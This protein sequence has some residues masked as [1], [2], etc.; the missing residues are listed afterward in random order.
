MKQNNLNT[1]IALRKIP[2]SLN[3]NTPEIITDKG[4]EKIKIIELSC[5]IDKWEQ[6]VLFAENGF[7]ALKGREAEEKKKQYLEELNRFI[8]SEIFKMKFSEPFSREA[9]LKIKEEKLAAVKFQLEAHAQAQLHEW[10]IST[11]EEALNTTVKRAVLYKTNPYVVQTAYM[12]GIKIIEIIADKEDW[13]NKLLNYRKKQ[14]IS[15]FYLALINEFINDKDINAYLYFN[16]FKDVIKSDEKDKLE[17]LTEAMRVNITANNWAKEIFSYKLKEAEFEKELNKI[18]DKDIKIAAKG[19]YSDLK[20]TE[21]RLNASADKEKNIANWKEI[22]DIAAQDIDKA[23]L[24]ID[25]SFKNESIK[26][27]KEYINQ[28]RETGTVKTDIKEFLNLFQE[29]FT[30]FQAFK[31]MDISDFH[32]CL[33]FEDFILFS[34]FQKYSRTEFLKIEFDIKYALNLCDET[35]LKTDEEKYNFIKMYFI[36]IADYKSKKKESADIE[37]RQKIIETL[38]NT[39]KYRK[40]KK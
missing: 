20:K 30:N 2:A 6:T 34:Q 9:V 25:Y 10:E 13:N 15:D 32:G 1:G 29:F 27:K 38:V 16:R 19:F 35:V 5:A 31:D 21:K 8:S 36:S 39:I 11:Y 24:Y 3:E 18:E 28:M 12:N 14:F 33:S 23:A 26:R 7:F 22:I 40:G 17:K 4:I 37:A